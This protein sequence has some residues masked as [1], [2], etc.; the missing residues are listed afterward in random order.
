MFTNF[1]NKMAFG[2]TIGSIAATILILVNK[3]SKLARTQ[4]G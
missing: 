4:R 2:L 3:L 1:D